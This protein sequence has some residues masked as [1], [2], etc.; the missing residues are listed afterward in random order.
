MKIAL[1]VCNLASI[2]RHGSTAYITGFEHLKEEIISKYDVDVFLHSY[3]C[4][5]KDDLISKYNPIDY[6]FEEFVDF[7][8][9]IENLDTIYCSGEIPVIKYE[10]LFSMMYSRYQVN[11]LKTEYEIN[12]NFKYDW[13]ICVRYDISSSH[14]AKIYFDKDFDNSYIYTS[15][16]DQLNAGPHDQWFYS[17][18]EKINIILNLY[19]NLEEY[20]DP[21]SDFIKSAS[22]DW[23]DSNILDR[24]S[25]EILNGFSGNKGEEIPIGNISNAH[26]IYKWHL[27]KNNLWDLDCMKFVISDDIKYRDMSHKSVINKYD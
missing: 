19:N 10:N 25:N 26:L 7:S 12:N 9:K 20:L 8:N 4:N 2:G 21:S 15:M 11:K 22:S 24:N 3:E 23:I 16:F 6:I 5:L 18:S 27:Y 13:V 14:L 1:L 17:N